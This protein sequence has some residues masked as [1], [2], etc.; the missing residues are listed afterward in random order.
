MQFYPIQIKQIIRET[1]DASSI[2]FEI[3]ENLKTTFNYQA[4]QYLTISTKINGVEERRAY[5]FSSSPLTDSN[6]TITVKKVE[7]GKISSWIHQDLKPSETV[8]LMP[9]MGKFIWQNETHNPQ[10]VLFAGGSGITPVMSILKT[11]LQSNS[12]AQI[13]LYYA[14]RDLD[15]VIFRQTLVHLEAT[16]NGR[17]RVVHILEKGHDGHQ[18]YIGRPGAEDYKAILQKEGLNNAADFYIC[19]PSGMMDQVKKALQLLNIPNEKIHTEYFTSPTNNSPAD[20]VKPVTVQDEAFSGNAE[21]TIELNGDTYEITVTATQTI[22]EAAKEQDVDPPYAC[23]M[24]VCTTCR[25]KLIEGKVE[26][27][28][29]EGLSDAEIADGYILTCQ[30]HPRSNKVHLIFE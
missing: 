13:T 25:A 27:T 9:P 4:G 7:G 10:L 21:T 2:V 6:P 22:L 19:G 26:M 5:S 15:S 17:L 18:G 20:A 28:E 16:Y 30:S 1:N 24:G 12:Q 29:R 23:Q 14:N 8:M 11:A 3:P